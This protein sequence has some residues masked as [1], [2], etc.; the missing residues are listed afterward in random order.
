M[1]YLIILSTLFVSGSILGWLL[2][3]FFRRF[4]TQKKWVN[5]GFLIGPY[6]PIY[7]IGTMILF[8]ISNLDT[9]IQALWLDSIIRI[10]LIGIAMTV[11]EF[12]TGIIFM[13]IGNIKLWDYSDKKGNV[14]GIICPIYSLFWLIIGSLYYFFLNNLFL[15][16]IDFI[17]RNL[18]YAYFIGAV[19]GAIAVDL[20]YS[21]HLATK[22][23]KLN[24]NRTIRFEE[25][26][27]KFKKK[28][29]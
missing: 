3:V 29:I 15:H 22:L 7:G 14:M 19:I 25:L 16:A 6:L 26:K 17:V 20:C 13:K 27:A 18:I 23:K 21:T 1:K 28:D 24:K 12:I 11:I 4:A 9:N 10:I 2:E 5:P 8:A